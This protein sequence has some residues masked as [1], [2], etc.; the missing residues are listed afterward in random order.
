MGAVQPGHTGVASGV[1]NAVARVASLLAVALLGL[2]LSLVFAAVANQPD[3]R[4][5][6]AG[7]MSGAET[8]PVSRD[9]FHA[10]FRAVILT[11]A[12]C[13]GVAGLVGL[14]TAPGRVQRAA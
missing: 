4:A 6:L 1:N 12:A 8:T 5:L 2:V 3:S 7:V 10:A 14:L 13:A 11:C 9:A